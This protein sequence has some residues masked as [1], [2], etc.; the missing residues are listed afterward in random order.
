MIPKDF[1]SKLLE[2]HENHPSVKAIKERHLD[3]NEF[4]YKSVDEIYVRKLINNIN[5]QTATG[6]N[7]IP[8]KMVKMC[9][10]ELSVTLKELINYAFS[11]MI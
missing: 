2:Q 6:Y 10:D 3:N 1:L 8:P 9:A 4:D 5:V 11:R 7:T